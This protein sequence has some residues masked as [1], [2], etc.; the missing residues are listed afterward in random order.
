MGFD[1]EVTNYSCGCYYEYWSHDFFNYKKDHRFVNVCSKH[2]NQTAAM[3][4]HNQREKQTATNSM[5]ENQIQKENPTLEEKR[6][7]QKEEHTSSGMNDGITTSYDGRCFIHLLNDVYVVAKEFQKQMLIHIRHFDERG[8]KKIPT[9]KGVTFNLSRWSLLETK[10]DEIDEM[11]MKTLSSE[12]AQGYTLH[13]GGGV[14]VTLDPK[15]PTVDIRHYWQPS[16]SDKPVPT[17]KGVALNKQK[18]KRLCN[19]I[20]IMREY[21][22]ELNTACV[23][24]CSHQ[25]ELEALSCKEC[26]PF[27]KGEEEEEW[28]EEV[29]RNHEGEV[30]IA[31]Y[32]LKQDN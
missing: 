6:S 15:F 7:Q 23:C 26:Y 12:D 4:D 17:R 32:L 20:E 5:M 13:L 10:K 2:L 16:D 11:F 8:Q 19:T 29:S 3:E 24:Y 27:E 18:W 28:K 22:P 21:V 25:N 31:E 9:K 1:R 14:H 30:D